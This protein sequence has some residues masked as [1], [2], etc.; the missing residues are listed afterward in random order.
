MKENCQLAESVD[1]RFCRN[2]KIIEMQKTQEEKEAK[3]N[4]VKKENFKE[5]K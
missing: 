3:Q 5:K 2:E 1:P 4:L